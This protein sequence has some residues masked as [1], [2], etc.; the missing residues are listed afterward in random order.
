MERKI[1]EYIET[2]RNSSCFNFEIENGM[3][4]YISLND[5]SLITPFTIIRLASIKKKDTS[6]NINIVVKQYH[7]IKAT[8]FR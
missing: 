4:P 8:L 2:Y 1:K 3:S 5:K 6:I 7:S